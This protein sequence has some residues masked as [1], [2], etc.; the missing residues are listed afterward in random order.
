MPLA[1]AVLLALFLLQSRGTASVG[2]LFGPVM[3]VWFATLALLG[4]SRRSSR[5]P[6][7][8]RRPRPALGGGPV[9]DRG[10]AGLRGSGCGR[11]GRSPAPR[12]STPTW[13]ISAAG[14]SASP[15]LGLVLPALV[16]NY[17]GQGALILRDPT[18]LD[19]PFYHLAPEWLLWPLIGLATMATIIASRR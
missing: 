1:A 14:R 2:A 4:V 19:H 6:S 18:A 7:I 16:L 15:G 12:R 3:L 11:A 13:A 17:F 5:T 9:P 10:L 8:L